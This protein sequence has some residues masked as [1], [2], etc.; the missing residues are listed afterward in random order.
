MRLT[1]L[2][3]ATAAAALHLVDALGTIELGGVESSEGGEQADRR[4]P[5]TVMD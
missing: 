3:A 4:G 5:P 2:R 1:N